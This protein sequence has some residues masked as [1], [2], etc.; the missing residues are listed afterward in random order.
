MSSVRR[1]MDVLE[2]LA[3]KGPMGVRAISDALDLPVTSI[4]R[5]VHEMAGENVVERDNDGSWRM[6]GRLMSLVDLQLE[7][8]SFHR[9]AR[10]FCEAIAAAVGETV[11]I[12]ALSG[13]GCV[14]IDKVRGNEKMQLDWR[15]GS[16]GPMHCG[17]AAKAILAFLPQGD[18]E[19]ICGMAKQRFTE[20]TITTTGALERELEQVR[21]RGCPSSI[22]LAGRSA[23]SAFRGRCRRPP[24]PR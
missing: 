1:I 19:R 7:S 16:R 11:N 12:N 22:G 5:L 23:Q 2:L 20:H 9:L 13:D 21:E 24:D 8:L 6:A 10:P 3:R 17:G 15:V 4:H 18:R 14:C